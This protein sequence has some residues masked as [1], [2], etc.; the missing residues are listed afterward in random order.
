MVLSKFYTKIRPAQSPDLNII[1]NIGELLAKVYKN[2]KQ[3]FLVYEL[4]QSILNA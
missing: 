1:D 3:D 2:S 4:K